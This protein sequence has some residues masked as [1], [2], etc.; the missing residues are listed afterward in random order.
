MTQAAVTWRVRWRQVFA[1]HRID[2]MSI[3]AE[4]FS[5]NVEAVNQSDDRRRYLEL[6]AIRG[7]LIVV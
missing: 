5:W 1:M 7:D 6:G 2:L 3:E 4:G